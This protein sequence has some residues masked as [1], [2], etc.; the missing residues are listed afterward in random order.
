[1]I[2]LNEFNFYAGFVTWEAGQLEEE[3][4]AKKWQMSKMTD[5]EI[6]RTP[7]DDLWAASLENLGNLYSLFNSIPDPRIN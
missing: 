2:D 4:D 7:S 6:F 3:M 5:M 1:M